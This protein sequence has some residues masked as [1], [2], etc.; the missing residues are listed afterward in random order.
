MIQGAEEFAQLHNN[1]VVNRFILT[2]GAQAFLRCKVLAETIVRL[3]RKGEHEAVTITKAILRM[4]ND[5]SRP[6]FAKPVTPD[7]IRIFDRVP[8]DEEGEDIITQDQLPPNAV[9][10]E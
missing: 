10:F 1:S 9:V 4:E 5:I 8:D 7:D 2:R 6:S 3:E